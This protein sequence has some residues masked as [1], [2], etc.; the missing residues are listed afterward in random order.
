MLGGAISGA[1]AANSAN[2]GKNMIGLSDDG[3]RAIGAITNAANRKASG[4]ISAKGLQAT[5]N[6]YGKTA[7]NAV[8]AAI[9]GTMRRLFLSSAR[10]IAFYTVLANVSQSGLN[11]G[12]KAWGLI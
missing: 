12:Y 7:F 4:I 8:Q 1:G 10:K 9:P 2:I 3:V 6:L 5:L 11:Y